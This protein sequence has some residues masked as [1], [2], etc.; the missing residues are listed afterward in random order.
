M[1]N[2]VLFGSK[3]RLLAG[4][5]GLALVATSGALA[6]ASAAS[7]SQPA[8]VPAAVAPALVAPG[9]ATLSYDWGCDGSYSSA[10]ITFASDGTFTTSDG[11]AGIWVQVEGFL[12]FTFNNPSDTTYT[13]VVAG[14]TSTGINT[15]FAGLNGCHNIRLSGVPFAATPNADSRNA[16]GLPVKG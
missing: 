1:L 15:T 8:A 4:V 14:S 12:T 6:S 11:G 9:T 3:R 5:A 7:A 16:A 10:T 13:S 2:R